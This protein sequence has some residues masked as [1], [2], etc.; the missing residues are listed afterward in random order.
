MAA[1]LIQPGH[2]WVHSLSASLQYSGATDMVLQQKKASERRVESLLGG[3]TRKAHQESDWVRALPFQTPPQA[4]FC[5]KRQ[6]GRLLSLPHA[7]SSKLWLPES[8]VGP[9]KTE[10][11][12]RERVIQEMDPRACAAWGHGDPLTF[13]RVSL[14][15]YNQL[16]VQKGSLGRS[17]K[18]QKP[19]ASGKQQKHVIVTGKLV[20]TDLESC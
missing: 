17:K 13:G 12:K 19:Q 14:T 9:P 6:K 4:V 16:T 20:T 15:S 5:T 1:L 18:V 2:L 7:H 10:C 3:A 8:R 11:R